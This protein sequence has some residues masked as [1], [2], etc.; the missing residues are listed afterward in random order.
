MNL[1]SS[2][3]DF[4]EYLLL[5]GLAFIVNLFP[6]TWST[7][8][9][10][11]VG[12][13][14]FLFISKRKK[15][16]LENLSIAYGNS[17]TFQEKEKI[18][19]EGIRNFATSL[20]E[21]FRIPLMLKGEM[22]RFE[23]EGTHLLD[24]A[25]AKGKGIVFVVSHLGSWEYLEFL[26][27]LKGYPCSVVVRDTRNPYIFPWI[28]ELRKM[29]TVNPI[30]KKG[31]IRKVLSELKKKH[32][33]AILIDQWDREGHLI[34]FFHKPAWTT[35]IPARLAKKTGAALVPG[36]CLRTGP[37]K[38]KIIIRPEAGIEEGADWE[39]LTTEK[40]NQLLEKE[41]LE[42]PEQWIWT[43]RRWKELKS[44]EKQ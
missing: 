6:I 8:I 9:V 18:A 14:F 15:I 32:I 19:R 1:I 17:L 23:F 39:R 35:S 29:T 33:V 21:F 34:N 20:M 4:I 44:I 31:A 43:H 28:Q 22:G 7:W 10:R 3:W 40:L 30:P 26:F 16:A 12:D 24:Q 13:L 42:H 41:I 5:R 25:F 36:Y 11:R 37:G 27:Y 2:W 38:Y